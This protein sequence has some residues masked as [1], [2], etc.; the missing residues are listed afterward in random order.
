MGAEQQHRPKTALLQSLI[1]IMSCRGPEDHDIPYT[2]FELFRPAHFWHVG[3]GQGLIDRKNSQ[4]GLDAHVS[5]PHARDTVAQVIRNFAETGNV[6]HRRVITQARE[7]L[8]VSP[9]PPMELGEYQVE[10]LE[11]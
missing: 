9:Y 11:A 10:R 1:E 3:Q 2:G 7:G 8:P 5:E 6:D 4:L